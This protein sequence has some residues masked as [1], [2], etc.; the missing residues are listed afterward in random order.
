MDL[1]DLD[2]N[3]CAE[4]MN[5]GRSTFQR[6][7]KDAKRKV[8]DAL[9]NGKRLIIENEVEHQSGHG[10]CG[11]HGQGQGQGRCRKNENDEF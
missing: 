7:Y 5:I 4:K 1:E 2:Q 9:V 10:Q 11:R 6:I 8:T 3:T